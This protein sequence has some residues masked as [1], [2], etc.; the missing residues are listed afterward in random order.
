MSVSIQAKAK[1]EDKGTLLFDLLVKCRPFLLQTAV[2]NLQSLEKL[3]YFYLIM[4]QTIRNNAR[5]RS[6]THK[7]LCVSPVELVVLIGALLKTFARVVESE[8]SGDECAS[9]RGACT[10]SALQHRKEGE[11]DVL[12]HAT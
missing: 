3:S 8:Q 5:R 1:K 6:G 9:G 10:P 4:Q 2:R 11:N 7:N 12:A